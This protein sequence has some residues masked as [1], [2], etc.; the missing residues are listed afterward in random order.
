[1]RVHYAQSPR[2]MAIG[3]SGEHGGN[4]HTTVLQED[5]TGW[6]G[7]IGLTGSNQNPVDPFNPVDPV[8]NGFP[9]SA[10]V[11]LA[12]PVRKRAGFPF[13]A[14]GR[15]SGTRANHQLLV[16]G[17]SRGLI[18]SISRDRSPVAQKWRIAAHADDRGTN[19][20]A[21][22]SQSSGQT[23]SPNRVRSPSDNQMSSGPKQPLGPRNWR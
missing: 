12:L 16:S 11:P 1:M 19:K 7:S 13:Q 2:A 3:R 20:P 8:K 17:I 4:S 14:L 18:H 21:G 10:R 22:A 23:T 6:T 5:E 15:A 9:K